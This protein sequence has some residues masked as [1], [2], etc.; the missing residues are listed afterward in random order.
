MFQDPQCLDCKHNFCHACILWHLRHKNSSCPTCQL[1]TRPSEV[2]R[3]QFLESILVAW[4]GVETELD[5]LIGDPT[6]HATRVT[7]ADTDEAFHRAANGT[8]SFIKETEN[9]VSRGRVA[10]HKWHINTQEIRHELRLSGASLPQQYGSRHES[11]PNQSKASS[12]DLPEDYAGSVQ[13]MNDRREVATRPKRKRNARERTNRK[14]D[15]ESVD[16]LGESDDNVVG[17]STSS[18]MAT[19][20]VESYYERIAKQREALSQWERD[21]GGNC[22]SSSLLDLELSLYSSASFEELIRE[23][24]KVSNQ[25]DEASDLLTPRTPIS[26]GTS[27]LESPDLLA[28]FRRDRRSNTRRVLVSSTSRKRLR[29]PVFQDATN[30][31][32]DL[33]SGLSFKARNKVLLDASLDNSSVN[34]SLE[35]KSNEDDENEFE[36]K[37]AVPSE[38]P[39]HSSWDSN[40]QKHS[41]DLRI[42]TNQSL[43]GAIQTQAREN[44]GSG[45]LQMPPPQVSLPLQPKQT[46]CLETLERP[47]TGL[48]SPSLM[49][50]SSSQ[51]SKGS[52]FVFVSSDLAR[53]D[54]NRVLEA[55][56]QMGGKFGLDFDLKRDS[57]TGLF[58]TSVTHLITK[59]VP[60]IRNVCPFNS[61]RCKRTAKYMRALAEGTFIV[62]FSWISASLAAGR[63]LTED[64][65]E[66]AG[67]IYSD[68]I[69]KPHEGHI[70]RLQTGRRNSI[71]S[72]LC[73]VLLVSENEFEFQFTSVRTLVNNFGGTI[74]PAENFSQQKAN[75]RSRRTPIGVVSKT[76]LPSVAK[77]KWLQF[78]IPIVRITW[79]F[80][81]VSHLE[82]LP[83][84]DY[85]P[86]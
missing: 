30:G 41:N 31:A 80:D 17:H 70:R 50:S 11:T 12:S 34:K 25:H 74:V 7:G 21:H 2:T 61:M 29:M 10:N 22:D 4:K 44:H 58:S 20:E 53:E 71:F 5:A 64:P 19:Q 59:A 76:T 15:V 85:Y 37:S 27:A 9:H 32:Y 86:Y 23:R 83:F 54:V 38:L 13:K 36:T 57:E 78:Q 40:R 6:L 55:I 72:L 43:H 56:H 39:K 81:S 42:D 18:L 3:N 24:Q 33:Y 51:L 49:R 77:A 73:F 8:T 84:D 48:P 45:K 1:P 16:T 67:D 26:Q 35:D 14:T 60:S 63:W 79:I 46:S 62:D 68:A 75:P 47:S 28:T 66:M 65:F 69:G 82:V 52:N